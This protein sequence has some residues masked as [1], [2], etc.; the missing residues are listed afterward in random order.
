MVPLKYHNFQSPHLKSTL[1]RS[2]PKVAN[3]RDLL[4]PILKLKY[5]FKVLDQF[6]ILSQ[7]INF[8][9]R[10]MMWKEFMC[11]TDQLIAVHLFWIYPSVKFV[12]KN[13]CQNISQERLYSL[14]SQLCC[15]YNFVFLITVWL[16]WVC[17]CKRSVVVSVGQW[18]CFYLLVK[19]F[20]SSITLWW[21]VK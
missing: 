2:S 13:I 11:Q 1:V 19:L 14:Y 17:I 16:Q 8:Q 4:W 10:Y 20:Q 12:K 5:D 15:M 9:N 7:K 21:A 3:L 6:W 18:I